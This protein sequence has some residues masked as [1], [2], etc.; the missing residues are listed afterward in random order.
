MLVHEGLC[1]YS[2]LK[3]SLRINHSNKS[4]ET[5]E[6][7]QSNY[8]EDQDHFLIFARN[9]ILRTPRNSV[10]YERKVATRWDEALRTNIFGEITRV[11]HQNGEFYGERKLLAVQKN[12]MLHGDP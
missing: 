10:I 8:C 1:M 2:P 7:I 3:S 9:I 4:Q 5:V 6:T 11:K 12:D